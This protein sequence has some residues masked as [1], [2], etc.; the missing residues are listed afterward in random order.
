LIEKAGKDISPQVN[1]YQQAAKKQMPHVSIIKEF[2]A[3][4]IAYDKF[5][6]ILFFM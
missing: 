2:G 6:G 5:Y 4:S 1:Y 3:L